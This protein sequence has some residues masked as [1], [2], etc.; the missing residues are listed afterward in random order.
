M[1]ALSCWAA[2]FS[3]G[4]SGASDLAIDPSSIKAARD[5]VGSHP[6]DRRPPTR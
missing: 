5:L 4:L 1:A 6:I 3:I 2:V